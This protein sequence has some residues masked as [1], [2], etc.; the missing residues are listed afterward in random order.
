[1]GVDTG[2]GVKP[3]SLAFSPPLRFG[4]KERA[5]NCPSVMDR[6]ADVLRVQ[7]LEATENIVSSHLDG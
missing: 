5:A 7:G 3:P 6:R 1:M 2:V 4:E